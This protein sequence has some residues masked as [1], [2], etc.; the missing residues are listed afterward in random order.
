MVSLKPVWKNSIP[1]F[2]GQLEHITCYLSDVLD[3]STFVWYW[4]ITFHRVRI[5]FW[6]H[7]VSDVT[8][9]VTGR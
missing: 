8:D 4:I 9:D 2:A 3:F 6:R 1:I 7:P 5:V